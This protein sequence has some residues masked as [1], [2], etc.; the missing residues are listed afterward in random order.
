M[1]PPRRKPTPVAGHRLDR[2]LPDLGRWIGRGRLG[3]EDTP[4][5]CILLKESLDFF[6]FNPLSLAPKN[7]YVFRVQ[8]RISG[9]VD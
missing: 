2:S 5:G 1:A 8:R 7:E 6:V 9:R 4:S 3:L